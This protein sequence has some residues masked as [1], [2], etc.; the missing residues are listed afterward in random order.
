MNNKLQFA[1]LYFFSFCLPCWGELSQASGMPS[2]ANHIS[3]SAATYS[4]AVQLAGNAFITTTTAASTESIGTGGLGNWTNA[5]TVT[6][7]YFR[8]GQIGQVNVALVASL[9][10]SNSS[11]IKVSVN[12]TPFTVNLSGTQSKTYTVGT[13]NLTTPGYVKVDLQGISKTGGYYGDVS[14]IKVGGSASMTGMNYADDA[15]N[16]YWSR[17]GPSV[18]MAYVTPANTEYFYNEV[19]VPVGQEKIGSYFMANGF[20]E[21]YFGMQVNSPSERRVL[22]SVWDPSVGK[23]ALA[24][25]GPGV[26]DNSFGGEGTGG[27]SYLVFNWSAGSTYKFLTRATPD[28]SGNTVY[29]A[30]FYAP[31]LQTWRFI[32]SW[33]RPNTNTYLVGMYSFVENFIDTNGYL[34]R[35]AHFSNQWARNTAGT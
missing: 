4:A 10:G 9:T 33:I 18:N 35:K 11:T 8:I 26:V 23:T 21:G 7:V 12:G 24:R 31:E 22:F 2:A 28:T 20:K 13:I 19:T 3:G 34:E 1:A 5:G 15:T 6:S 32:A 27:Q 30:W 17:R 16:F 29:S 25:K 14:A